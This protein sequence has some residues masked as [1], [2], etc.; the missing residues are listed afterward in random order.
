MKTTNS[1]LIPHFTDDN[2]EHLEPMPIYVTKTTLQII[3]EENGAEKLTDLAEM[4]RTSK[5]ESE[6]PGSG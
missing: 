1:E 6:Q 2:I 5:L 3:L 4:N